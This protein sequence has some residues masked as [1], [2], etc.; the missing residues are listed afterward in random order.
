M[1]N[2]LTQALAQ[3]AFDEATIIDAVA[4]QYELT[5]RERKLLYAIRK[6]EQGK[7]GKEFGVLTPEAMRFAN[8][9]DPTKSFKIQAMW[10]AG[11]IKKRF[12][13]DLKKFADRWAPIGAGNDPTN[14]NENWLNNV[15][16]FMGEK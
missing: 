13:G 11:T 10:A 1:A 12:K 7:Q 9:P 2:D 15:K 3:P 8:D 4:Q 14:L 5:E 6:A 16:Y